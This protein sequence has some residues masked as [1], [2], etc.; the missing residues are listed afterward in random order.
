MRRSMALAGVVGFL[1][2]VGVVGIIRTGVRA[3]QAPAS[4]LAAAAGARPMGVSP[5]GMWAARRLQAAQAAGDAPAPRSTQLRS[6][7]RPRRTQ[8][9][10]HPQ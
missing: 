3:P 7:P 2:L 8:G 10:A 5:Y 9:R 6:M 4:P 1:V